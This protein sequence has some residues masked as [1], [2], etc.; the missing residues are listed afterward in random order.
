MPDYTM[1]IERLDGSIVEAGYT[2]VKYPNQLNTYAATLAQTST[3]AQVY[4]SVWKHDKGEVRNKFYSPACWELETFALEMFDQLC[5]SHDWYY[6]YSDDHT[7]WKKGRAAESKLVNRWHWM[8]QRYP[9]ATEAIW[10]SYCPA[11][12]EFKVK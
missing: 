10:N 4:I 5:K 1:H 3:D 12:M 6:E 7:V 2:H 9:A 11:N 8:K